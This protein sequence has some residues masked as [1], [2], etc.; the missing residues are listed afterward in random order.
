MLPEDFKITTEMLWHGALLFALTDAVFVPLLVW[1]IGSDLF[2]Q[3]KWGLVV[4]AGFVWF[5]IWSWAIGNF[6]ETVYSYVFPTWGRYLIPPAFGLLMALV[7][8]G[9]WT[10][11]L[12]PRL[13]PVV[14][15]CLFGGLWGVLT[16]I[17]AIYRGIV[18]KPPMLLGAS[19]VAAVV[20]AFFEY[21]FYWCVILSLSV[22][23]RW[24]WVL[25]RRRRAASSLTTTKRL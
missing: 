18:T 22:L 7:A 4:S 11:A 16:H 17:W 1:R 14:G 19:P 3:V 12:W 13:N 2:H 25:L 23:V 5:G 20:I 6:W 15:Y 10:L 24:G 9:L 21:M 8:L